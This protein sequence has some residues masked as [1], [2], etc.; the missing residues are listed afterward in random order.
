L[1]LLALGGVLLAYLDPASGLA[2]R[3][4]PGSASPWTA[5]TTGQAP[6]LLP[7]GVGVAAAIGFEVVAAV[8]P[9]SALFATA[10]GILVVISIL[11]AVA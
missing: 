9:S 1:M 3:S 4:G 11:I 6:M 5:R 2:P 10:V 7:L 8:S